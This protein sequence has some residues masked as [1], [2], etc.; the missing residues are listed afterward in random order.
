MKMAKYFNKSE[1]DFKI[2]LPSNINKDKNSVDILDYYNLE[3]NIKV[4]K[5][6]FLSYDGNKHLSKILFILSHLIW[7][8]KVTRKY[9]FTDDYYIFTRS[10]WVQYFL[11]KKN[12]ITVLE[13]HKLSK[14]TSFVL[15]RLDN[16]KNAGY[17]FTNK[18]LKESYILSSVQ[19]K[20]SIILTSAFDHED[21]ENIEYNPKKNTGVFMGRL[22]RYGKKRNIQF[23]IDTFSRPDLRDYSLFIIGGPTVT[24]NETRE[25][26]EKI[27]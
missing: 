7:S 14:T 19:E 15:N 20:N 23:L 12:F 22:L 3:K 17:V 2:V 5:T 24:S 4:E 21:F 10:S 1:Y 8:I 25:Y 13:I 16:K 27:R 6:K 26:V 18:L 9:Q 11:A